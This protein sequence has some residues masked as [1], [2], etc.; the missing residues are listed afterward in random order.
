[1]FNLDINLDRIDLPI[2]LFLQQ[3]TS[4]LNCLKLIT[5][6]NQKAE[7]LWQIPENYRKSERVYETIYVMQVTHDKC[8][9]SGRVSVYNLFCN[10]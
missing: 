7:E 10:F 5:F 6:N 1:M 9:Q 2:F 8:G 3:K 4:I